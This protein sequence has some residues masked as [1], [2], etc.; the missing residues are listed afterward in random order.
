MRNTRIGTM[1]LALSALCALAACTDSGPKGRAVTYEGQIGAVDENEVSW[2]GL[3]FALVC[4]E[5]LEE[6][7]Q[8]VYQAGDQYRVQ[9]VGPDH[10]FSFDLPAQLEPGWSGQIMNQRSCN[11]RPIVYN[12]TNGNGLFDYDE[13]NP[14]NTEPYDTVCPEGQWLCH[15]VYIL[16]PQFFR[17]SLGWDVTYGW[18]WSTGD[19]YSDD[20][21]VPFVLSSANAN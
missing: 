7:G 8:P 4:M 9:D 21:D 1:G 16:A 14:S 12:D 19:G 20:F 18:N 17:D 15:V 10:T 11:F 5:S 3:K 13:A 6:Y 2:D